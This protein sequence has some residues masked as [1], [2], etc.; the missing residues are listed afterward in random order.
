LVVENVGDEVAVF[1]LIEI[2]L[3]E[4]VHELKEGGGEGGREGGNI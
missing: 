4:A 3:P 2:E 1:L